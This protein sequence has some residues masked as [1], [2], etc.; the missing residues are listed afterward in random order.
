MEEN[1]G[2]VDPVHTK[3]KDIKDMISHINMLDQLKRG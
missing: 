3:V 2:P 1:L